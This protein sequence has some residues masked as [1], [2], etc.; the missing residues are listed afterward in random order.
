M[1]IGRVSTEQPR[2]GVVE[3]EGASTRPRRPSRCTSSPG[4]PFVGF[5]R[6]LADSGAELHPFEGG[7]VSGFLPAVLDEVMA[8]VAR[9]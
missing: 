2:V 1:T 5:S 4:A 3:V 6:H 9:L 7:H 8:L